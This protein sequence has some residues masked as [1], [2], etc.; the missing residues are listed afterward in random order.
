MK[1]DGYRMICRKHGNA[2]RIITRNGLDWTERLPVLAAAVGAMAP[3]QA[4]L[5]GELVALRCPSAGR[6]WKR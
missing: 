6:R 3:E 1:F 2:V 4:M 5:D